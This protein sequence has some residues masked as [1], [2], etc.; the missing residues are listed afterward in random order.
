MWELFQKGG[1]TMYVLL[2]LSMAA[3]A[4][5]VERLLVLYRARTDTEAFTA[6]IAA[7]LVLLQAVARTAPL[8]G[9]FGT[10][11]GMIKAFEAIGR[12]GLGDPAHV[13]LG[14]SEALIT[15]AAGLAVAIPAFFCHSLFVGKVNRFVMEL[16]EGS[17]RFLDA[18]EEAEARQARS[19][20]RYEIGGEYLEV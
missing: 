16:E 6:R 12:A 8:V 14:I 3:V 17:I 1:P 5:V 20:V 10:V 15:T 18:L 4:V 11:S 9:F 7:G 13:A 2:G 19:L